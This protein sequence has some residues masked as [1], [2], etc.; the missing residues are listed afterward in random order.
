MVSITHR[1]MSFCA[2]DRRLGS[3]NDRYADSRPT[4]D[5]SPTERKNQLSKLI[6]ELRPA[7]RETQLSSYMDID[8]KEAL[9]AMQYASGS[10]L[11]EADDLLS[12]FKLQNVTADFFERPEIRFALATDALG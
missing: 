12:H 1:N 7:M 6:R 9:T 11:P 4:P 5:W 3:S 2:A 8:P 10:D